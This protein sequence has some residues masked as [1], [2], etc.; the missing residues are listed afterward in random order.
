[1]SMRSQLGS[2]R[3]LVTSQTG[4]DSLTCAPEDG[5]GQPCA[6]LR[7]YFHDCFLARD[8]PKMQPRAALD[9][10]K[11]G[12]VSTALRK[13]EGGTEKSENPLDI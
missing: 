8:V 13:A 4:L 1:M 5:G 3:V 6:A 2:I 10:T 11:Q 7:L 12:G 9:N